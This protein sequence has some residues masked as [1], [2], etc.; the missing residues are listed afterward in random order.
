MKLDATEGSRLLAALL[1]EQC[2][3]TGNQVKSKAAKPYHLY[4]S[5]SLAD[6]WRLPESPS[7]PHIL[8]LISSCLYVHQTCTMSTDV[9]KQ[10]TTI[11]GCQELNPGP[12][13]ARAVSTLK[14]LSHLSRSSKT[15]FDLVKSKAAMLSQNVEESTNYQGY[16]QPSPRTFRILIFRKNSHFR[17]VDRS[18]SSWRKLSSFCKK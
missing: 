6:V 1:G 17:T 14:M 18:H 7:S 4:Q 9:R 10:C 16:P 11:Y 2:V 3:H 13:Y 5:A 15:F 12:S 8:Y